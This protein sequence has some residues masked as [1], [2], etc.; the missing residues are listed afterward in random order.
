M[1]KAFTKGQKVTYIASWDNRGTVYFRH[2]IVHSCGTKQMVLTDEAT[3][4]EMGR[5]F[6]PIRG[7]ELSDVTGF[8][9]SA[10]FPRMAHEEA[11]AF[12][13]AVGAKIVERQRAHFAERRERFANA[14]QGYFDS[15]AKDES[16]L[17]EPRAESY[18][19]LREEVRTKF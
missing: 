10:T 19:V 18:A 16:L 4:A 13:L 17:H 14:G 5:H 8:N 12:C 9:W 11:R 3:G 6:A 2:A 15:I 7:A 1:A